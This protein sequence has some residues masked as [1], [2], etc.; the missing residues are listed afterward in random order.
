M[1]ATPLRMG[2]AETLETER[3]VLRAPQW[4]DGPALNEA[5]R[6]SLED[7]RPWMPWAQQAP[8]L[9]ASQENVR[10]ARLRFLAGEDLRLHMVLKDTGAFVGSSGLHRPDW[11]ARHFEIGYWVRSGYG[12]R[13]LVTEAVAAIEA[14]AAAHLAAERLEIRCDARNLRSRRV[15][16]RRGFV[17]EGRLRHERRD[18]VGD[19]TDTLVY[20]KVRGAEF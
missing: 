13:G 2:I 12:G 4:D 18:V 20:A 11:D 7:L 1:N 10:R 3:L 6:D 15:A 19:L 14:Y 8:A 9:E 17:L 5:I 16:D